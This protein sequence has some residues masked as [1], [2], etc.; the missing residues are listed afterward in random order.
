[1]TRSEILS[2]IQRILGNLALAKGVPIG[3]IEESTTLLGRKLPIDSL[4][5]ATLVV[6]L[7]EITGYDPFEEGFVEFRTA[8][9]LARLYAR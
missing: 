6:E 7:Q 1:M 9:E 5:L 2:H 3:A 8:G 4:D